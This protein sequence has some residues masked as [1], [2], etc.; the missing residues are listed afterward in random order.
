MG[1][2]MLGY[3]PYLNRKC[4]GILDDLKSSA[5]VL[6][7][8]KKKL[9]IISNDLVGVNK[10]ITKAVRALVTD[11][12]GI[13]SENVL[14]A[15]THTHSGPAT[16][17]A[18]AWGEC[19]KQYLEM[20]PR[21]IAGAVDI[22]LN[23]MQDVTVRL[24]S[25]HLDDL[26][27]NRDVKDGPMDTEL[28][29]ISFYKE[30]GTPYAFLTNFACHGVT[31]KHDN[32]KISRDYPGVAATIVEKVFPT[33]KMMFLQGSCGDINPIL[34]HTGKVNEA[35]TLFAGE[36][37]K[38]IINSKELENISLDAISHQINLPVQIPDVKEIQ[39]VLDESQ[40]KL[41]N[42]G[43]SGDERKWAVFYADWAKSMLNKLKNSPESSMPAE[44]QCMRIGDVILACNPSEL[45]TQFSLDIKQESQMKTF[46]VAYANDMVG[47]IPDT[48]NF[49]RGAYAAVLVPKILDNFQFDINVGSVLEEETLKIIDEMKNRMQ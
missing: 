27:Y 36:I 47:Y 38:T 20:L 1:I 32:R 8:D 16:Y 43:I 17:Y 29:V 23:N 31:M 4:D 21:E 2:E 33:A 40:K 45:F 49:E 28:G 24:G 3:G 15:C 9:V 12:T 37:L 39:Q 22:A 11:R 46:V 13:P 6:D 7:H 42:T 34:V 18:R 5:L 25:G 48:G 19:D 44:I 26:G 14:V 30:D 35:G 41:E 10:E